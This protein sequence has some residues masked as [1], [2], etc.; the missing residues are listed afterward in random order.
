MELLP[1]VIDP[2]LYV[3]RI[4]KQ[5]VCVRN[6]EKRR[7]SVVDGNRDWTENSG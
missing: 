4:A 2:Y 1:N 6:D 5:S 7:V 3:F